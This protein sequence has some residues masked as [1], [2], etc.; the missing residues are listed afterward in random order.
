MSSKTNKTVKSIEDFCDDLLASSKPINKKKDVKVKRLDI[1]INE[2]D[3][4]DEIIRKLVLNIN[5]LWSEFN[6][7]KQYVEGTYCT[8]GVHNRCN[9][10]IEK[11]LDDIQSSLDD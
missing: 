5:A 4:K 7:Y 9:D 10:T 6:E 3:N 1:E 11:R 8:I 2:D